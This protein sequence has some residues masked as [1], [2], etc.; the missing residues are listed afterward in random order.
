MYR[1]EIALK[2]AAGRE[3]DGLVRG[4]S[5]GCA[6]GDKAEKVFHESSRRSVAPGTRTPGNASLA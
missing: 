4:R 2:C 3:I 5:L 6:E 1:R